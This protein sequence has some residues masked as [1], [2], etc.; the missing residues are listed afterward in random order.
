MPEPLHRPTVHDTWR[1]KLDTPDSSKQMRSPFICINLCLKLFVQNLLWSDR[2]Q[3][4]YNLLIPDCTKFQPIL[5]KDAIAVEQNEGDLS[6]KVKYQ[7]KQHIDDF[8]DF[9][10]ELFYSSLFLVALEACLLGTD[11][12]AWATCRD[13]RRALTTTYYFKSF[14]FDKIVEKLGERITK[15]CCHR[16]IKKIL[17]LLMKSDRL[18]LHGS[19]TSGLLVI[20][21]CTLVRLFT[22]CES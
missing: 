15:A 18:Q 3:L 4:M 5:I 13:V 7:L 11:C 9:F 10:S 1:K 12:G 19:N 20:A 14:T 17:R 2:K 6:S 21:C 16:S 8:F 22:Y